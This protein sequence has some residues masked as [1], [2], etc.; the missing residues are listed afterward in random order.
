[1][2][3]AHRQKQQRLIAG[4]PDEADVDLSLIKLPSGALLFLG[5]D[6]TDLTKLRCGRAVS[7]TFK[8]Q[9]VKPGFPASLWLHDLRGSHETVLLDAGAPVH[10]VAAV[11]TRSGDAAAE[12]CQADEEGGCCRG[13]HN[14]NGVG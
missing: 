1:M 11:A 5:D 6:G 10:V 4:L 7:R 12:L 14:R 2:L 3:A 9:V 8:R 13:G